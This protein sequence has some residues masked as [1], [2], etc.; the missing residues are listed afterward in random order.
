MIR[1]VPHPARPR[2]RV[3]NKPL[4]I[5]G[6]RLGLAVCSPLGADNAELLTGPKHA[7]EY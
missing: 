6:E 1:R 7:A 2:F 4:K 5:G 3:L